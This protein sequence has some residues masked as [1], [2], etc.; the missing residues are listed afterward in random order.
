MRPTGLL[1][2]ISS[3][4]ADCRG[5]SAVTLMGRDEFDTAVPVSVVVPVHKLSYP[6]ARLGIAAKRP[7]WVVGP[8]LDRSEQ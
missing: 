1:V 3:L 2:D 4:L 5:G 7:T 6:L 8:V